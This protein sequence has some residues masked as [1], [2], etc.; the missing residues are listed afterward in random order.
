MCGF[1]FSAFIYLFIFGLFGYDLIKSEEIHK[2]IQAK[3]AER[4]EVE[5]RCFCFH[6]V[7]RGRQGTPLPIAWLLVDLVSPS[8]PG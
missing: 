8:S 6:L 7:S 2:L 1:F 3:W 5:E 4:K